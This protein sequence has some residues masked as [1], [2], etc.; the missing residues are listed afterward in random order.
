MLKNHCIEMVLGVSHDI[1]LD[2]FN[3][4]KK[5][6]KKKWRKKAPTA[7]EKA[8]LMLLTDS[9]ILEINSRTPFTDCTFVLPLAWKSANPLPEFVSQGTLRIVDAKGRPVKGVPKVILLDNKKLKQK[10]TLANMKGVD[11]LYGHFSYKC[12]GV[13]IKYKKELLINRENKPLKHMVN[14]RKLWISGTLKRNFVGWGLDIRLPNK[15]TYNGSFLG[16]KQLICDAQ[17]KRYKDYVLR[18]GSTSARYPLVLRLATG[19]RAKFLVSAG[20]TSEGLVHEIRVNDS[21][22]K[23]LNKMSFTLK[24]GTIISGK[25][26]EKISAIEHI[27]DLDPDTTASIESDAQGEI[28]L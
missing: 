26:H 15:L 25:G 5:A 7:E 22:R 14:I 17:G 9:A 12:A 16:N 19:T 24:K 28:V 10:F 4:D 8:A 11:K 23:T 3:W 2:Q 27:S 1:Y 20:G 21:W 6:F 18:W 13:T